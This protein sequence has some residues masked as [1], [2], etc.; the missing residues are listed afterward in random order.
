MKRF[1]YPYEE[2]GKLSGLST[3]CKKT[4][5]YSAEISKCLL[6]VCVTSYKDIRLLYLW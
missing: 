4:I 6:N 5:E 3:A 1:D 2:N